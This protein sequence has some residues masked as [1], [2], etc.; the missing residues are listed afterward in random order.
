MTPRV[1][2]RY[3]FIR[4]IPPKPSRDISLW[5]PRW[6]KCNP[7]CGSYRHKSPKNPRRHYLELLRCL[8]ASQY[9]MCRKRVADPSRGPDRRRF[10]R[11]KLAGW[12]QPDVGN[13]GPT[14]PSWLKPIAVIHRFFNWGWS[15]EREICWSGRLQEE[16]YG[17]P[18]RPPVFSWLVW[19]GW[20]PS[21]PSALLIRI[22]PDAITSST[23]QRAGKLIVGSTHTTKL[24]SWSWS[25]RWHRAAFKLNSLSAL[26]WCCCSRLR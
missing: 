25:N 11:T 23:G 17:V 20:R 13:Y 14:P 4:F 21:S 19:S 10:E 16:A 15:I 26:R 1:F 8:W 2:S 3:R 7:N 22:S 5:S 24:L 6:R 12:S 18:S 9:A